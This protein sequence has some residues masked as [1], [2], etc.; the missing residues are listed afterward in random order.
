MWNMSLFQ[1]NT[2]KNNWTLTLVVTTTNMINLQVEYLIEI[3]K[4]KKN[5]M[6]DA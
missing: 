4:K 3:K 1:N 6:Y 2:E 5:T